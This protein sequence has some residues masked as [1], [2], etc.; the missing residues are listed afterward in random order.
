M[1]PRTEWESKRALELRHDLIRQLGG[2]CA[3]CGRTEIAVLEIDH[4]DGRTWSARGLSSYR[5]VLRY[6]REFRAGVRLRVLCRRCNAI[7]GA[8]RGNA[9]W[10]GLEPQEVPF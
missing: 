10:Y 9:W 5:R 4:V 8:I 1:T 7:D 6:W 2:K 3:E